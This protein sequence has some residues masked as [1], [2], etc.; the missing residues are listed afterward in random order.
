MKHGRQIDRL[1]RLRT[2]LRHFEHTADFGD[3]ETVAAIRRHLELRI[4]EAESATRSNPWI[5]L[6]SRTEAA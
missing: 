6:E 4:R 3:A 1:E 2:D 5:Q